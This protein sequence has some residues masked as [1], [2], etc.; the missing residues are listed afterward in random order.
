MRGTIPSA[1]GSLSDLSTLW[2]MD[3]QF[4][5][6]IPPELGKLTKLQQLMIQDNLLEGKIPPELGKLTKL[7]WLKLMGNHLTGPM[8]PAVDAL[9]LWVP[10]GYK[11]S[12]Y[13]GF[14]PE[15][16]GRACEEGTIDCSTRK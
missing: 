11:P 12:K 16:A 8:P 2:L 5:G 1:L 4:T 10:H 6:T 7:R 15:G 14:I 3:N 13:R 9:P